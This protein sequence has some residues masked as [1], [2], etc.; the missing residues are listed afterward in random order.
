[1]AMDD[2]PAGARIGADVGGTFTDLVL[3]EPDGRIST[4][5][6]ASSPDDFG[7]AI[8]DGVRPLLSERDLPPGA[9]RD[10]V[11]G[12]TVATNAILEFKGAKTGLLTTRGFRDVLEMR[13]LRMPRLYELFWDK[14]VPLVSREHR[15]EV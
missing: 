9:L 1:M 12:T 7:R 4:R 5:K 2:R 11:H 6:V 13:R 3:V 10:L 15:L 14:P 8:L